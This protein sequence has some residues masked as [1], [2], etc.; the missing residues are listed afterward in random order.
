MTCVINSNDTVSIEAVAHFWLYS[1]YSSLSAYLRTRDTSVTF[2]YT[3]KTVPKEI[4]NSGGAITAKL[5]IKNTAFTLDYK[6][7]DTTS[8]MYFNYTFKAF[9][10]YNIK[11][12]S[13]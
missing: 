11:V 7:V 5:T 10:T 1:N 9:G 2:T 8:G 12:K 13:Y 3:G 6:Y 4:T